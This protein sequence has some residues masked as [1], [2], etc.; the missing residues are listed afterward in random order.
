MHLT[1]RTP[2]GVIVAKHPRADAVFEKYR[3]DYCCQGDQALG[4]A[5]ASAGVPVRRVLDEIARADEESMHDRDWMTA[6]LEDVVEHIVAVHHA[7]LRTELPVLDLRISKA[8][9]VCGSSARPVLAE[10][11][12]VFR[13]LASELDLHLRKEETEL[14][15]LIRDY[16][17]AR[18]S[19]ARCR[20]AATRGA[21]SVRMALFES[22]HKTAAERLREIRRLTGDYALPGDGGAAFRALSEGLSQLEVSLHRHIHLE[23]NVLFPR[24]RGLEA[25]FGQA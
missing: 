13:A 23:N 15:P 21:A 14:F 6:P 10:V 8:A 5:C 17:R 20:P 4:E 24:T 2:V 1:D 22:E 19:G 12:E 18:E 16:E 9:E 11:G 25:S 3:I 7:Y